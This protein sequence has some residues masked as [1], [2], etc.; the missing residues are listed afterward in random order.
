MRIIKSSL[1]KN[2]FLCGLSERN[3][4]FTLVEMSI[5]LVIVGI[6]LSGWIGYYMLYAKSR[7]LDK[8]KDNIL[9]MAKDIDDWFNLNTL[10]PC[11]ARLDLPSTDPNFGVSFNNTCDPSLPPFNLNTAALNPGNPFLCSNGICIVLGK[12]DTRPPAGNEPIIVG[13]FPVATLGL[14]ASSLDYAAPRGM[15]DTASR[16]TDLGYRADSLDPWGDQYTYAVT[17]SMARPGQFLFYEGVI[18]VQDEF[19]QPTAGIN[20][21]GHYVLIS[22]GPNRRGAFSALTG[23]Q[24]VPCG[25]DPVDDP[26]NGA[27]DNENCDLDGDF[28]QALGNYE[29]DGPGFY[30]DIIRVRGAAPTQ[31]WARVDPSTT[32]A[33]PIW[34]LN[35]GNIGVGTLT[36]GEQLEVNGILRVETPPAPGSGAVVS[37]LICDQGGNNDCFRIADIATTGISCP[38]GQVLRGIRGAQTRPISEGG[39]LPRGSSLLPIC[40]NA[41][42]SLNPGQ[43]CPAGPPREWIVG[44]RSNGDVIC[45]VP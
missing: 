21:D 6:I 32:G 35:T 22:H 7:D 14:R 41:S 18:G 2:R 20:D 42:F 44:V 10:Y 33:A 26:V 40:G 11:P 13:A 39:P 4:G 38:S 5:V 43:T 15:G 3:G 36:P 23:V 30:D 24:D 17:L 12:R 8:A 29:A 45:S 19:G 31:I 37:S 28:L 25:Q 16:T 1:R 9:L 27:R 34:N